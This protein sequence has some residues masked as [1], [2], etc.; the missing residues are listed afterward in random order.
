MS[1]HRIVGRAAEAGDCKS[2]VRSCIIYT[3]SSSLTTSWYRG[4]SVYE[5]SEEANLVFTS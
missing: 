5:Y 1:M 2:N 3:L 4:A